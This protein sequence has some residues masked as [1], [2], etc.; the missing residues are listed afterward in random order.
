MPVVAKKNRKG[1]PGAKRPTL[2]N[3]DMDHLV[4]CAWNASAAC[5][6]GGN[7]HVKIYPADGSAMIPIPATPSG[8]RTYKN[9]CKALNRA[10]IPTD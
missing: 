1:D 8:S 9:K 4:K 2:S 5:I 7:Q 6:R 10:G 3:K